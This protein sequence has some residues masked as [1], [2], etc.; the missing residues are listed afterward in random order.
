MVNG[1]L[2]KRCNLLVVLVVLL[3]VAAAVVFYEFVV[4]LRPCERETHTTKHIQSASFFCTPPVDV[5]TSR[6]KQQRGDDDDAS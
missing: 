2:K 1:I 3:V 5:H 4:A 6:T